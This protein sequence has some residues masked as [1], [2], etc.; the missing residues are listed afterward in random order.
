M[1]E[2]PNYTD[3]QREKDTITLVVIG[4]NATPTDSLKATPGGTLGFH[5]TLVEKG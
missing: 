4:K 3:G 1:R 2:G 5:G